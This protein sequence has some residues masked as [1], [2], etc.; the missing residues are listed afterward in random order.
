MEDREC[1]HTWMNGKWLRGGDY[2][3]HVLLP[4]FHF[5]LTSAYASLRHNGVGLGKMDY[6]GLPHQS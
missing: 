3:E 1:S 2:L 6:L 5:H 4:N